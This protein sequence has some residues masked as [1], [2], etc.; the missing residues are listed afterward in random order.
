MAPAFFVVERVADLLK[1]KNDGN[2]KI[3][4]NEVY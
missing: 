3:K 4:N 2:L 1:M